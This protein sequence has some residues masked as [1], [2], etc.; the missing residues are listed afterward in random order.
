M[1][2]GKQTLARLLRFSILFLLKLHFRHRHTI[3]CGGARNHAAGVARDNFDAG[4]QQLRSV[5][6]S[7]LA[8]GQAQ[9]LPF[10]FKYF[11]Q[12]TGTV[13]LPEGFAPNRIKV[14]VDAAE[15][16]RIDQGFAWAEAQTSEESSNVQQQEDSA[17]AAR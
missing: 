7:E 6:W 13:M 3:Q 15:G 8:P 10:S 17:G 9:G 1:A 2:W 5:P 11:Q 12:V 4:G 16:G 14:Q